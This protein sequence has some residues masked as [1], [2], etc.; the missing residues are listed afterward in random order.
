M[1]R[2]MMSVARWYVMYFALVFLFTSCTTQAGAEVIS[3]PQPKH[4]GS[5]SVEEAIFKRKSVRSYE[6]TPLTIEEVSQLLWAAGGITVDG[7]T[8]PTRA[9]PSAGAVYPLEIYLVA[10]N[11]E[12]IEPGIY[13]YDWEKNSLLVVKKGDLRDDLATACM[14]QRMLASAP[15]TIVITMFPAKVKGAYGQRGVERYVSMDAGHLGE[16]IHLEAEALGLGTVM[17]GAF[18]DKDVSDVLGIGSTDEVPIYMMPVGRPS[19]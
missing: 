11:V 9:Y 13:K 18:R 1:R 2:M 16:N 3:L 4:K 8:G 19:S 17:V 14:G 15:A 12:G 7:V 6:N 5:V 10:G